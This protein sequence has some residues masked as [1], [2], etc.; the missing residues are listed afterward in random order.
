MYWRHSNGAI[1]RYNGQTDYWFHVGG[2]RYQTKNLATTRDKLY[3][4]YWNGSI[5]KYDGYD[6]HWTCID[7]NRLSVQIAASSIHIYQLHNNG[8]IF[9]YTGSGQ[10]WTKIYNPARYDTEKLF[11]DNLYV[12]RFDDYHRLWVNRFDTEASWMQIELANNATMGFAFGDGKIY[13]RDN[14]NKIRRYKKPS[15]W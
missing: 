6:T 2:E 12:Y 5:F 7:S 8:Q 1:W 11:C 9:I 3:Q 10:Q 15:R 4:Q 13:Q 14:Y